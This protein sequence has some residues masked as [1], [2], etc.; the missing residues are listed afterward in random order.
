MPR[1]ALA[2]FAIA[3]L[4][5]ASSMPALAVESCDLNGEHVNPN[6]G[7]T[8]AG[9][10]GLMRCRDGDGDGG[11]VIR[12]Q[13]LK[14]G[15]F[16]GVV[17]TFGG[18]LLE[19]EYRVNAR[20]NRDGTAHEWAHAENGGKPVLVRE[21]T[22]RDGSAV[23]LSRTWYP[24]GQLSRVTFYGDDNREQAYAEFTTQGKLYALR[25]APRPVLGAD[26]D[27]AHWCGH[28]GAASNVVLYNGKGE[29]KSRVS[30]ERGERRRSEELGDT[31]AVRE[32][33]ETTATGGTDRTFYADGKKQRE[34]QWVAPA[35]ARGGRIVTLDQEYHE[36][37]KLVRERRWTVG[38]RG[39]ELVSEQ[40]WYLNGQPQQKS[41]FTSAGGNT[42]RTETAFH[43]N[44]RKLF[45]GTWRVAE[46]GSRDRDRA[47][48]VHRG[49]DNDGRL[50]EER[51]YDERGRIARE[52]SFDESGAVVR[53]DEVF[54]DGSRKAVGR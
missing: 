49:W 13:E 47:T 33:R 43:D 26:A 35:G 12:E 17:R 15:V 52:R 36:S 37:G 38:A 7:N 6:N 44:G 8:T 30:Y 46:R 22:Y 53:D 19:R 24:N 25:C 42:L 1:V 10:T 41:E 5:A 4:L 34:Q 27:D 18:G 21:E 32:S 39:G 45:E 16:I 23:G 31:G 50:R 11:T 51:H 14:G 9:K 2:S 48:G 29:E 3:A 40:H 28:A 20:G 54:E